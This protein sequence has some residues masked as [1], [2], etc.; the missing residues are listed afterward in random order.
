M[1]AGD[2][3]QRHHARPR[4]FR[5]KSSD[6][7]AADA[8]VKRITEKGGK[9]T[10]VQG[11][12]AKPQDIT[13]LFAKTRAAYGK[14]DVLVNNAGVYE[15]LPLGAITA[16]HFHKLFNVNVLGLVLTTQDAGK[17]MSSGGS[18]VNISSIVGQMPVENASVY[19]ATK[20]AVDA[21]TVSLSEEL[22]PK[23]IRV[24]SINPG[25]V[26][27]DGLQAAGL[28]DGDLRRCTDANTPLGRIVQPEDIAPASVFLAS[29]D[30][31]WVTG[32]TLILADGRRM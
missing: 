17:L 30:A 12:L 29:D 24:N 22:G 20:A 3:R 28:G 21:V 32:Q 10:A 6:P 5:E 16:D 9:A 18:I 13:R 27:T 8:V 2:V 4:K 31:R 7:V 25:M 26:E 11:D 19:R 23:K 15:F 14:L 1:F